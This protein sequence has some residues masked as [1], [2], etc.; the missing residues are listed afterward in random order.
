[1][2]IVPKAISIQKFG[3][4]VEIQEQDFLPFYRSDTMPSKCANER[5]PV[6][7]PNLQD[8]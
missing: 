1:M 2:L 4:L 7:S 6:F 5:L 8:N 3:G